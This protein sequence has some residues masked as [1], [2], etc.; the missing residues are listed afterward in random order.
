MHPAESEPAEPP[1]WPHLRQ[2]EFPFAIVHGEPLTQPPQ[3]LYIPPDALR[4]FLDAFEGPLDLLLYL[5]RRQ[6]LDILNI[7][8]VDIIDQYIRYIDLLGT[9]HIELAAE[10]LVMAA[11][12]AEIKSRM[13]LPKPAGDAE[14]EEADPRADLIRRLQEYE[15]IKDAAENMDELGRME[16][17][18]YQASAWPPPLPRTQPKPTVKLEEFLQAMAELARREEVMQSHHVS[19]EVLPVRDRMS[20][21]LTKINHEDFIP[22]N[23]LLAVHEGR[24]GI[25]VTFIALMELVKE[26]LAEIVQAKPFA[27]IHVRAAAESDH[28]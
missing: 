7:N 4:I 10:Y 12:L 3:D 9:M 15:Q 11:T 21:L 28:A 6:N 18:F 25:V 2:G 26:R 14:E 8:V 19:W 20:Q 24:L 22:F 17:N 13:L 5:I 1:R 27:L 23:R 16:R